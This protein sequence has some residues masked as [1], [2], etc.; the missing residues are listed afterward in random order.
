MKKEHTLRPKTDQNQ[1]AKTGLGLPKL[2]CRAC[3]SCVITE[4]PQ[5]SMNAC[6]QLRRGVTAHTGIVC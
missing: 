5:H 4:R 3:E 1:Q 2:V 6:G